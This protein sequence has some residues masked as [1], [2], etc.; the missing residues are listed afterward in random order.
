[1]DNANKKWGDRFIGIAVHTQ[2]R[3]DDMVDE[4]YEE[5]YD[6]L[7]PGG[8]PRM[9]VNRTP[10]YIPD[11]LYL[12]AYVA[13]TLNDNRPDVGMELN[14]KEH[15]GTVSADTRLFFA[16]D[17]S[18][19]N[20]R[21]SYVIVENNVRGTGTKYEQANAY[22]DNA[23]GPMGGYEKLGNPIPASDMTYQDVA[24]GFAGPI[25]GIEGSIPSDIKAMEP[26]SH[27]YEFAL[28]K[29][30]LNK[31][32]VEIVAM[33]IDADGKIVNAIK[34]PLKTDSSTGINNIHD[35]NAST[36]SNVYYTI[37]GTVVLNP[38]QP[39]I[40]IHNGKKVVIK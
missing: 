30:V 34:S 19:L 12:D 31:N 13:Y 35:N 18:E 23:S 7:N 29:S 39:G 6:K 28:P 16:N 25:N 21:M 8:N 37:S 10:E 20:Y 4:D 9:I 1:M 11:P 36:T 40:Y 32:N 5:A 24:R 33:I 14:V 27:H 3:S 22:A 38:T 17:Q 15:D 2:S 26:V